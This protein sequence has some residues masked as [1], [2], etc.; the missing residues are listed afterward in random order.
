MTSKQPGQ[1]SVPDETRDDWL[2][3]GRFAILLGALLVGCFASIVL[4]WET[5]AYGDFPAFGYPLAFYHR[6]A[7]WH[8]ELP[9][10]NPLNNCGTPFLAQ[11]N[12][13]TLY[14]LSLFYL[15]LPLSWS[16]GM[17]CLGHMFLGGMGTYF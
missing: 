10:W 5:F 14:P 16:L 4:G 15:L 7:F 6:E 9:L 3:P 1:S 17:F 11:W 2:T 8:G 13:L 12:T